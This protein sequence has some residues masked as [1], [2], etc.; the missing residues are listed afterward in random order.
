MKQVTYRSKLLARAHTDGIEEAL[1]AGLSGD[2]AK[3]FV[4]SYVKGKLDNAF[5]EMGRGLDKEA[6]NEASIATF[7]QDLLPGTFGRLTQTFVSNEKTKLTRLILPFVKTPTNVIRYGVKMTPG[8]NIVQSEYRAM[9]FGKMG[10]EAQAQA[11][12][13]PTRASGSSSLPPAGDPTPSSAAMKT[14]Q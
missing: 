10:K 6:L 1:E 12:G 2:A 7:Q 5:D 4:K 8:L 14:A 3:E 13:R 11:A 9:L